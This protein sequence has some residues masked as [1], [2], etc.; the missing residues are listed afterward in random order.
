MKRD[1]NTAE[2]TMHKPTIPGPDPDTRTPKF[3]LPALACDAHTH[4]FGPGDKYPYAPGRPYTPPDAPLEDFRALHKKLGIGRAVIVNASVH[5][6]DNRVALDAIAVSNGT[7][8]AVANIDDTITERGLRELHEGGFRGC[9][10][11][12]VRH[13][14]GVPD[15]AVFHRIVAMVAPLGWHIDLHFDAIDL[16]EYAEMLAKLPVR[17][18][19]DHMGRVKASD[20]LDQLPF[21]TLIDL[22]TRDEKCWVKVCGCER[23]SSG[24]PPF[25]DAVPFARR[26][27]ETAPDRVI[28]GTDWPHPNV[29]VMP[30]DGDLVDL[31]PLVCAGARAAAEDPGRQSGAAVR[32]LKERVR[33]RTKR[34]TMS[35][36]G[37]SFAGMAVLAAAL[38]LPQIADAQ[39]YP[40]RPVRLILPFGAGGVADVTARLVTEKLGEKLGQRFVIENM[41]GAGGINAARAVLSAPADG[42]TLALL[43]NGT[44]ISVSLFK[45]LGFNPVTDFVPVSSMGYFDFIFVTQAGSPYPT[46]AEFIKAAKAKPGTLNVG[47]INVGSTQNLAAQLFKST[48]GVDVTIVPFR[49]SPDVLIALLRGDIQ[50]A[51]ENYTRGAV[52]CCRQGGHCGVVFG[53]DPHH[54]PA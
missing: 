53:H 28:W 35:R 8:R 43:S 13:L 29:K 40:N 20:G 6:T 21:R 39:N 54:I 41:A 48:A 31:I 5:G 19:I 14:G 4:I 44:A 23:V 1:Q 49:S 27:V 26:I 51:I 2:G 22:M 50:M 37:V 32:V 47:T 12:F 25:H 9:R 3:K 38:L 18:T 42:Y 30:N 34:Y 11:N 33:W 10:F 16:P 36:R 17:Y 46:L 24:G 7:F 52:A 45:S 15:M